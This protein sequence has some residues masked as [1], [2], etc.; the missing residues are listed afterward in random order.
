MRTRFSHRA[1]TVVPATGVRDGSFRR[2]R[3]H[4]HR[5]DRGHGPGRARDLDGDER[6]RQE[7]PPE[8]APPPEIAD[9]L[10]ALPRGWTKAA[11][12]TAG[13]AV[14]VPPGWPVKTVGGKTTFKSP[15]SSVVVA[16]TA[17]RSEAAVEADLQE[18]AL[19][20][21]QGIGASTAAAVPE[22]PKAGGARLRVRRGRGHGR[23][24]G[25][26]RRS[27]CAGPSSPP[28]RS[29]SSAAPGSSRRQLD[30]IVNRIV[31]DPAGS[32]RQGRLR[33]TYHPGGEADH[34][35]PLPERGGDASA[36]AGR[37]AARGRRAS[38][39]SSGW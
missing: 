39:R 11:N 29:W 34:P 25:G 23:G 17:D 4:R 12:G 26:S 7:D 24:A 27:S 18:Y 14:G 30:P 21:A 6:R 20:V 19:E 22:P 32:A 1:A 15:G 31:G 36:D 16:I 37:A 38:T 3:R 2:A 35:D 28:I 10:P 9:P 5:S 8:L 33:R 13:F